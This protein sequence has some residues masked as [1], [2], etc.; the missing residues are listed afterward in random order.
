M[1]VWLVFRCFF[2]FLMIRR[3]PRSTR[4]DTLFPYTTLF[5][6]TWGPG[7]TARMARTGRVRMAEP[8]KPERS[9][10]LIAVSPDVGPSEAAP[11]VILASGSR[12]RA[13]MLTAAGVPFT[14]SVAG[15]DEAAVR[16][17]RKSTRLN[18]SH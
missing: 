18:S 11:P 14:V 16:E 7:G 3:P 9:P 4:T 1:Y 15:V 10:A 8:G 12:F 13:Q 2:F 17:D 5:R 6:S